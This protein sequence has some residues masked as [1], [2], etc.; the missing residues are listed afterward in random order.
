MAASN[1]LMNVKK[2][3][4]APAFERVLNVLGSEQRKD[5]TAPIAAKPT[6]QT[7]WAALFSIIAQG[8]NKVILTRHRVQIAG[9]C[10]NVKSL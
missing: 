5:T 8:D 6:V 10:Q 4:T 9:D 1:T 7:L 3:D 2:A